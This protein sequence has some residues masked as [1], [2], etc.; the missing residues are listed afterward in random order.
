M[1]LLPPFTC[2]S[3][4]CRP[5]AARHPRAAHARTLLFR[6]CGAAQV[7]S[8][9]FGGGL[10]GGRVLTMP[11]MHERMKEKARVEAEEAMRFVAFCLNGLAGLAALLPPGPG[12][13]VVAAAALYRQARPAPPCGRS[14]P[15]PKPRPGRLGP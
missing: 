9:G 3:G 2:V 14:P 7:G 8:G 12:A 13:G 5:S 15:A 10:G 6:T 11:E 1:R 4:A